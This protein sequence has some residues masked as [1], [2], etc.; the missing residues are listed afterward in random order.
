MLFA[1]H[2]IVDWQGEDIC[3][4]DGQPLPYSKE[5]AFKILMGLPD[6]FDW[7][8][9]AS[10]TSVTFREDIDLEEEAKN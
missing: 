3:D 10:T 7:V 6:V 1:E 9:A 8:V 4:E 5:N 2:I